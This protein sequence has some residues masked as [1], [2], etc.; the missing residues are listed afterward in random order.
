MTVLIRCERVQKVYGR[1][2]R[3]KEAV[4]PSDFEVSAGE[5]VGLVGPNGAGKT[6][7]LRMIGGHLRPT[8]G[9]IRVGGFRAGTREARRIIGFGSDP[10]IAPRELTGLEWLTYLASHRSETPGGRVVLV[11][12]A[13]ELGD[14][15]DFARRRTAEYSRGMSQ[16][17]ALAA[18]AMCGPV[19][20]LDETL[21]GL[22]PIVA[23]NLRAS[24]AQFASSG[25]AL[26][27]ATHDLATVERI[28]TRAIILV[29]GNIAASVEMAK[30]LSSRV[31][32]VEM[33][34]TS[35]SSRDM[36]LRR[37]PDATLI[38]QGIS[39]PLSRGLTIESVLATCRLERVAVSAS[40]VR[41]RELE[42]LLVEVVER[43]GDLRAG[44]EIS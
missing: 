29:K 13:L 6:T 17:L 2:R 42:D 15:A 37:F 31:A 27:I 33:S 36:L 1:G 7:L 14:L 9:E 26:I 18:A 38:P 4:K 21:S 19:M 12:E 20:L 40:R 8:S 16:Q 43:G 24:I 44:N 34:R 11:S 30:L 28:A 39:V 5:I 41:Y 3:A 10:P 22:D 32:E 23:K 25:K 35:G